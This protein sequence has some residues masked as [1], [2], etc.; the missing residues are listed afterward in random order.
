ME[1]RGGACSFALDRRKEVNL[2][3]RDAAEITTAATYAGQE[4]SPGLLVAVSF[5]L[6]AVEWCLVSV[7][8]FYSVQEGLQNKDILPIQTGCENPLCSEVLATHLVIITIFSRCISPEKENSASLWQTHR[9]GTNSHKLARPFLL[10]LLT[11][12]H[13]SG[14]Y[15]TKNRHLQIN[16]RQKDS[17][18]SDLCCK[19][20][21]GLFIS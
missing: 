7:L 17:S 12:S 18:S 6:A 1:V 2:K 19:K 21:Q 15:N 13:S 4:Q 3:P 20:C 5:F 8:S 14:S 16:R 9:D 10:A 11:C